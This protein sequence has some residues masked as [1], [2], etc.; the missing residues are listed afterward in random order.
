M[1]LFFSLPATLNGNDAGMD[2]GDNILRTEARN[3]AKYC[4]IGHAIMMQD[5]LNRLYR[6]IQSQ[7]HPIIHDSALRYAPVRI[8]PRQ[9]PL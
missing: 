3:R 2:D 4:I 6:P 1:I 7:N 8:F 9:Q 5:S